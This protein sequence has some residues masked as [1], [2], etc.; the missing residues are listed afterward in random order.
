MTTFTQRVLGQRKPR[1]E[2][3]ST[4]ALEEYMDASEKG[5][6]ALN[7][8]EGI[9][10]ELENIY[11]ADQQEPE[12]IQIEPEDTEP[13]ELKAILAMAFDLSKKEGYNLEVMPAMEA[14]SLERTKEL[15]RLFLETTRRLIVKLWHVVDDYWESYLLRLTGLVQVAKRL[16][17]EA[18]RVEGRTLTNSTLKSDKYNY[19]ST[20]H[21]DGVPISNYDAIDAAFK[22]L[23]DEG[24][25]ILSQWSTEVVRA[26]M[27]VVD[28]LEHTDPSD[29]DSDL[30]RC[31]QITKEL[32]DN[33]PSKL[34]DGITFMSGVKLSFVS[35]DE[36]EAGE[37][38]SQKAVHLMSNKFELD[39]MFDAPS[40]PI[41]FKVFT[42][43]EVHDL[44]DTII[45][46]GEALRD[47]VRKNR[48]PRLSSNSRHLMNQ[49]IRRFSSMNMPDN[50]SQY[51][52]RVNLTYRYAFAY[53]QWVRSPAMPVSSLLVTVSRNIQSLCREM[54]EMYK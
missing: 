5:I 49:S 26:G 34:R 38:P 13:A 28:L 8:A 10:G 3:S 7:D 18:V 30:D 11:Q 29:I 33:M 42:L 16:K 1:D 12:G 2:D 4:I 27:T 44:M 46:L 21:V 41:S 43:S 50:E 14:M 17:E 51:V 31:N 37:T 9:E 45:I 40:D 6:Q 23:V 52:G 25:S 47:H 36:K 19:L 20:F 32:F 15:V 48:L 54:L 39:T 35:A 22:G 24:G 53:G